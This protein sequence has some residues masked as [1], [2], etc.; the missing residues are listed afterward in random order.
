MFDVHEMDFNTFIVEA[1]MTGLVLHLFCVKGFLLEHNSHHALL[2]PGTEIK[3]I[4]AP[5]NNLVEIF[6]PL[7]LQQAKSLKSWCRDSLT[8]LPDSHGNI[9]FQEISRTKLPFSR[10]LLGQNY[11]LQVYKQNIYSMYN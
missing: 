9:I 7:K 11:H 4:M 8:W 1:G 2:Q 10:K 5:L 3:V 6:G